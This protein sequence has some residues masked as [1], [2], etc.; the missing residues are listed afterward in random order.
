MSPVPFKN[1][2]LPDVI[3]LKDIRQVYRDE[4]TGADKVVLDQ[5]NLLVEKIPDKGQF[6]VILGPSGCGKSTLLRF[7][8]GIQKPTAGEVM[9]HGKQRTEEVV[10]G[11]VFQQYSSFPWYTVKQNVMLPL[12]FK[13]QNELTKDRSFLKPFVHLLSPLSRAMRDPGAREQAMAMIETVGLT[14]HEH[15]F[16]KAPILSGGQLQ[17]VA[18]ARS[19]V[20]NP[21]IILM[22]EPFGALD[23]HTRFKMQQ[24]LRTELW[25][26][27]DMSIIFVTHDIQE[28]VFLAD[29][30][31]IM[32]KDPGYLDEH[33][34]IDLPF[35][36]DKSIKKS[37]RFIDLVGE[38]DDAISRVA[39]Q[40]E[41]DAKKRAKS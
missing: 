34:H 10:V 25:V 20:I 7:I 13:K 19:L 18:I 30:I 33:Y 11:M 35:E 26:K 39:T 38:I 23:T 5:L 6:I 37:K 24:L 21:G 16:A 27:F 14:G 41:R 22:D 29:D 17:R 31:Y 8:A 40:N 12:V 15:K 4:K 3:E 2:N 36:R 9:I 32:R 1:T 28:A